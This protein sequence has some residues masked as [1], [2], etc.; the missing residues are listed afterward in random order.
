MTGI[1]FKLVP[2]Q[3]TEIPFKRLSD[4]GPALNRAGVD[5]THFA[6]IYFEDCFEK[7]IE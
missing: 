7:G 6:R 3:L 1:S 5:I 2:V 4:G